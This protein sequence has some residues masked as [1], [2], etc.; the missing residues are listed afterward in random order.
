MRRS[1]EAALERD[2]ASDDRSSAVRLGAH[3]A[4]ACSSP[5]VSLA[6]LQL[7]GQLSRVVQSFLRPPSIE[8]P[9][10]ATAL[11]APSPELLRELRTL[12]DAERSFAPNDAR[13]LAPRM[14]ESQPA[15]HAETTAAHEDGEDRPTLEQPSPM[16]FPLP[17]SPPESGILARAC[18]ADA[19]PST[20]PT[21][22]PSGPSTAIGAHVRKVVRAIRGRVAW[23]PVLLVVAFV[24]AADV[25]LLKLCVAV[26]WLH[27]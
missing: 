14:T 1:K 26:V 7:A 15:H 3:R 21:S 12:R 24:A 22:T 5:E 18:A 2:P 27:R 13:V 19:A 4:P 25:S 16:P 20:A 8:P 9:D 17:S 23:R 6:E 11:S 10:L